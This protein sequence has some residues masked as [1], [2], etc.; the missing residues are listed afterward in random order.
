MIFVNLE[1]PRVDGWEI[2]RRLLKII[3]LETSTIILLVDKEGMF[4]RLQSKVVGC[5]A[6]DNKY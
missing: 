1:M 2:C 3:S 5:S 6:I 4:E